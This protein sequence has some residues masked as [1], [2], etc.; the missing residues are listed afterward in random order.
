M[1]AGIDR[2]KDQSVNARRRALQLVNAV[3]DQLCIR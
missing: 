1:K 2:V 3:I